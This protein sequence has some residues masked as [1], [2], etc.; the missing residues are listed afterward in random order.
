[1]NDKFRQLIPVLLIILIFFIPSYCVTRT[2]STS[3]LNNITASVNFNC[4]EVQSNFEKIYQIRHNQDPEISK[5]SITEKTIIISSGIFFGSLFGGLIG[6]AIEEDIFPGGFR[7]AV[8]GSSVFPFIHY[9]IIAKIKGKNIPYNTFGIKFGSN[10]TLMNDEETRNKSYL[11]GISRRYHLN[12]KISFKGEAFYNIRKFTLQSK[13]LY[14]STLEYTQK[15]RNY[16][17]NFKVGYIDVSVSPNFEILTFRKSS[18]SISM[19]PTI[20]VPVFD[21]TKYKLLTSEKYKGIIKDYDLIYQTDEPCYTS[22]Y[23]SV[24]S[25]FELK[26]GKIISQIKFEKAINKSHQIFP[27]EDETNMTTFE[28]IIEYLF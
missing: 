25:S 28:F 10:I 13:R 27:L 12:K 1:M 2:K 18:F 5:F 8:I 16:D 21:N 6:S 19:G 22:P 20:S 15:I 23:I 26:I 3:T 4:I 7:G 14:F 11:M 17:I 24:A 9:E